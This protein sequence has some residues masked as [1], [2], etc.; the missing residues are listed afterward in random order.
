MDKISAYRDFV[1]SCLVKESRYTVEYVRSLEFLAN[2]RA[3]EQTFISIDDAGRGG[4][5]EELHVR[6]S[7]IACAL[8]LLRCVSVYLTETGHVKTYSA[9]N[10]GMNF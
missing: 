9:V 2:C 6:I 5:E 8:L 4:R 1:F 7:P 10:A 3:R